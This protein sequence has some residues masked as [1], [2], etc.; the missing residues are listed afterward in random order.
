MADKKVLPGRQVPCQLCPLRKLKIFRPFTPEELA[1][2]S[3]FKTGEGTVKAGAPLFLEE[4]T[5][6]HLYTV[7]SGLAF[8]YKL[9][10]DGRRQILNYLLPGDLIGLQPRLMGRRQTP[11]HALC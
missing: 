10:P 9:L 5:S 7:L 6:A 3:G 1:F 2:V 11:V 4:A 8:R